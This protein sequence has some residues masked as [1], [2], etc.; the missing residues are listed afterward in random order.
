MVEDGEFGE[1]EGDFGEVPREDE[2]EVGDKGLLG[3]CEL[4]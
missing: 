2:A 1:T 3:R 4:F